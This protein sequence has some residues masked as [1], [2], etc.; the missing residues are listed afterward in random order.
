MQFRVSL[1]VP[2]MLASNILAQ[3]PTQQPDAIGQLIDEAQGILFA[4]QAVSEGSSMLDQEIQQLSPGIAGQV[5]QLV[6]DIV[7]MAT[8]IESDMEEIINL[9][10]AL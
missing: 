4:S 5:G 8:T 10:Q 9:L 3:Q 6:N 2:F 1:L 7:G